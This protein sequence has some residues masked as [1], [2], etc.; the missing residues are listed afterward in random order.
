MAANLDLEK[1]HSA[2]HPTLYFTNFISPTL[3]KKE[4]AIAIFC[5]LRKALDT[6]DHKFSKNI[7]QS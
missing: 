7:T 1:N 3:N 6:V 2:Q 4:H 5:D